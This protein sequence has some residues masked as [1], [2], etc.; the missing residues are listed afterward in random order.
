MK[1]ISSP[2][3]FNLDVADLSGGADPAIR[4]VFGPGYARN[5]PRAEGWTPGG[6]NSVNAASAATYLEALRKMVEIA[7]ED[8]PFLVAGDLINGRWPQNAERLIETFGGGDLEGAIR[9][10]GE[11][12]YGWYR[13]LL[14][15]AG[16]KDFLPAIG[17]HEIGDNDW[18]PGTPQA[19]QVPLMKEVFGRNLIDPMNLSDTYQGVD[20]FAPE[21]RGQYDEGNY[22]R[23]FGD[24]PDRHDIA[25]L[26]DEVF[27][28]MP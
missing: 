5:A 3:L 20:R 12:Y 1:F 21:G 23:R 16:V 13:E 15:Q 25:V 24:T 9:N 6:E 17:D 7:G 2:D 19:A 18:N 22:V 26:G 28:A 4:N 8:A 11:V 27:V 10:A 14:R